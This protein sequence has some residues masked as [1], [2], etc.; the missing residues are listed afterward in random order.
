M[1]RKQQQ[2]SWQRQLLYSSPL[3]LSLPPG[4]PLPVSSLWQ[5]GGRWQTLPIFGLSHSCHLCLHMS[6]FWPYCRCALSARG[7]WARAS[8]FNDFSLV[9]GCHTPLL[10]LLW[11]ENIYG[12]ISWQ[13]NPSLSCCCVAVRE[14]SRMLTTFSE[15]FQRNA[16]HI[17]SGLS[18]EREGERDRDRGRESE[19]ERERERGRWGESG[20][21]VREWNEE[22]ARERK[23]YE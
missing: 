11:A 19:K 10:L 5:A 1:S 2:Q 7:L 8:L 4:R 20:E 17:P 22:R 3:T 16:H 18:R 23:T 21:K 14:A 12:H 15:I 13:R 6:D 9:G